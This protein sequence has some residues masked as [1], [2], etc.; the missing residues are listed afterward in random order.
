MY[1]IL[2]LMETRSSEKLIEE[3]IKKYATRLTGRCKLEVRKVKTPESLEREVS[4]KSSVLLLDPEGK[5]FTSEQF[6]KNLFSTLD[7]GKGEVTLVIGGATGLS[8]AIKKGRPL[9]SLS[10]LTFPHH[11]AALILV[12]Q[13]YRAF[14]I[15]RGSSYHK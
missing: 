12:E 15:D 14:E 13:I 9:L 10:P 7:Q 8:D 11:L 5:T 3:A 1:R 2:I 6:S 4:K